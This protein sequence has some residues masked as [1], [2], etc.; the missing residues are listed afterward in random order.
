YL[1]G[2]A[3]SE[4]RHGTHGSPGECL[5]RPHFERLLRAHCYAPPNGSNCTQFMTYYTSYP[6]S[7]RKITTGPLLF[8][9]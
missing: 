1:L 3:I 7:F 6:F 4:R 2:S 8:R 5:P 9:W